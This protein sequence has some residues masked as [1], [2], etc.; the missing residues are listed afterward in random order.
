MENSVKYRVML[1]R[2][3]IYTL[4][5][6]IS[7]GL[8][9]GR[10]IAINR[11]DT[12][13]IQKNRLEQI[14][15]QL[16]DKEKRLR[17]VEPPISEEDLQA[18]LAKTEQKL[19][20][21]AT[22]ELPVFSA[23]DR[24]RWDTLRVLVEPDMRVQ[25]TIQSSDGTER[26][27]TVWYAIDKAQ[28]TRGWDTIDMVKHNNIA[29]ELSLGDA[30]KQ[31]G[32]ELVEKISGLIGKISAAWKGNAAIENDPLQQS[33]ADA[34]ADNQ[35][36]DQIAPGYLYSSKPP[37]LPT[38]MAIPYALMY[39]GSNEKLSLEH[40]PFLVVRV[41][42]IICN[43]LPLILCWFL[44]SRLI[45]RFGTTNWG[46]VFSV[47]FVCFGTFISTFVVT[48]NNHL[49]AV[50][51]VTI[52]LYCAVRIV[53]DQETLW[54]YYA[55]AGFFGAFATACDLPALLFCVLIG[56]W[57]FCH[58]YL[59]TLLL[60]VP[61]A[62]LVAAAFFATNYV[63]HKTFI[64][65]YAKKY[66]EDSWYLYEYEREGRVRQSYW[67]NP[68]GLDK[69]E[70]HVEN[71]VFHS[72]IGHHGLF[73]LTP[74]WVLSFLGLIFWL[75]DRR[76]RSLSAIILLTS[77]VVFGFYMTQ[78]LHERN[79]GGMTS[80]LRWLFW[81]A[82]LWSVALVAAADQFGKHAFFRVIAL[83]CLIV[84]AMSAAYPVWNPWTMPWAY[85]L[86]EYIR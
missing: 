37:L 44:L 25:R 81:L 84:S 6:V 10:I 35:P 78:P 12:I 55:A 33:G 45:E 54:R 50:V 75:F 63:A 56:F 36:A 48:L 22:F 1:T 86:L 40:E 69:G 8:M 66:S 5:I 74:V 46:R 38:M 9:L 58:Q 57:I 59:R 64:P 61:A 2:R 20:T 41:M 71:Y 34:K 47:A 60:F 43:L 76:Y 83:L 52:A 80:A 18:E 65:A 21:D 77:A 27:E 4:L 85:N 24:S 15:K 17:A 39:W 68:S 14:P 11:T 31:A 13:L 72:T 16:A 67:G 79:Y 26:T 3:Q 28:S 30:V 62:M 49:P 53:Y 29:A 82:P 51:S 73:S 23:N 70:E 42:L 32:N 7:A 19:L